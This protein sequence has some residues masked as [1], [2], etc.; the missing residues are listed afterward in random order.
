[1]VFPPIMLI[2]DRKYLVSAEYGYFGRKNCI[3]RLADRQQY[4]RYISA[5]ITAD[6]SAVISLGRTLVFGQVEGRHY[7]FQLS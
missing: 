4:C 6:I 5:V 3:S 2:F 7:E 1:M